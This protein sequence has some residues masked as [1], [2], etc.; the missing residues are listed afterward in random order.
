MHRVNSSIKFALVLLCGMAIALAHAQAPA[1]KHTKSKKATSATHA[2]S[3]HTKHSATIRSTTRPTHASHSTSS[4]RSVRAR[5]RSSRRGSAREIASS[6]HRRTLRHVVPVKAT[7]ESRRL[8]SA[9]VASAQLRPMAQELVLLRTPAAYSG[10]QAYA[11]SHPGDGAAAADLALGHAYML[12]RRYIDA[13][14]AFQQAAARSTVLI[15]Y[16][17]YLEAH[18][19]VQG[20]RPN[21]AIP[22]LQHFADR[23]PGSLFL[24]NAPILLANAYIAASDPN[25]AVHV[26][27][28]LQAG[29]DGSHV[30]FRSA[31]AHAY[32]ASG[33]TSLAA[34]LYRGIYL[35]DPVSPEAANAKT[36]LL[37]MNLPLTAAER[38]QHAD[39][40]FD[41]KQYTGAEAEYRE[42]RKDDSGLSQADR[43]ALEIYAAVCDLR[44]KKLSRSDVE[45][46]PVTS[47]DSAAL[48][49]YLQS[50][51]ARNEG[52][53]D[54]HDALVQQMM[55][56]FPQS[57]WLEEA[58][59]S[60]GNMYLIKRDNPKAIAAYMA[61]VER[62]PHSIYAPNAHWHAAW[63]NYRQRNYP[64]AAR[65]MDEQITSYPAGTEIPGALYW[66]GRLYED[67]EHNFGQALNY[68]DA[69]NTNY[70]NSYYAILA[71]QR[72]AVIGT[73]D[74]AA[75]APALASLR[76][77]DDPGFT[78][79][80][81]ENDPH[82]IKAR[83]LANAALNE[84]IRPEI[85]LSPTSN[86]WGAFAEAEIYQSFGET[87]RALQ[88]MKRSRIPFF[89]LAVDDVPMTYWQIVFP[90]PF[91]PQLS[92][93]AQTNG[94]DPF[95]VASLI[96]QESEFNPGAV[97]R[98]NAYGLMQLLPSVG[99]SLAKKEGDR[100][101][102][103]NQ[104]LNPATNLQLGTVDLRKSI[105]RYNGQI[106]YALAAYNAGDT[107][108]RQWIELNDYKDIP[109]WVESIPYTETRDYVQSILRNREMYRA[110]Y[111]GPAAT[112][113]ASASH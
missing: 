5:A 49:M 105:D 80:L 37:A 42:L 45:H 28:P 112:E 31:L 20:N 39:A 14:A 58:L 32:Q 55:T 77:I 74:A 22:L 18:A 87:T 59:Y 2:T 24:P 21:D 98:A 67:V 54:E 71:R 92:S 26:L 16:A 47:D 78:D 103:T 104:L 76:E 44:L 109:E 27:L 57:R 19:A 50:E 36:Q 6:R 72:L 15:D 7:A 95:L 38:K 86:E 91:W 52:K 56:Q 93:D 101:F 108:V 46:L 29:D 111:A 68:Y 83:L 9:F 99:K 61:L 33:N 3:A 106:E 64:E 34:A 70:V 90:R 65:L 51:L 94:L 66:R 102:N 73:R 11:A 97:S 35:G 75:P 53:S 48:K 60:G 100:H 62:F 13:E 84:Y 113:R 107:P 40:L 23:H 88:A 30:S 85:Q 79:D 43:D 12:D 17:D 4:S 25:A 96:R 89:S 82:L 10:V 41:A 1:K 8:T 110:V 81:P 69:L 63:L